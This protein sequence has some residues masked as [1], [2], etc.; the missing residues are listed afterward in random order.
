M[1]KPTLKQRIKA[2]HALR[3]LIRKAS[4]KFSLKIP[5]LSIQFVDIDVMG[6]FDY[7]E[8]AIGIDNE[9]LALADEYIC[10][11][12]IPHELAHY[13]DAIDRVPYHYHGK[14]FKSI[15]AQLRDLQ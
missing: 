14:S 15:F 5:A 7:K 1:I 8:N 4:K 2:D 3:Q 13:I 11:V 10:K 6:Y 9:M 12:I